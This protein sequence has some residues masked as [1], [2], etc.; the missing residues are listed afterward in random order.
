MQRSA[1]TY[2]LLAQTMRIF[3]GP[4]SLFFLTKYFS[5][6]ELGFYYSFFSIQASSQIIEAG[7]GF[8]LMQ[9]IARKMAGLKLHKGALIGSLEKKLII[10]KYF[11]FLILWQFLVSVIFIVAS[12]CI[13]LFIFKDYFGH[14]IWESPLLLLVFSGA[15]NL[16]ISCLGSMVEGLQ[17]PD[18][19]YRTSLV[20]SLGSTLSLL[21]FI[22]FDFGLYSAGLSQIIS[23]FIGAILHSITLRI[24]LKR[25][26]YYFTDRTVVSFQTFSSIFIEIRPY[27]SKI[28]A[29]WILG[30]FYWNA[31]NLI[32]FK[33]SGAEFAGKLG[34]TLALIKA[35]GSI[36]ESFVT[37]K[38]GMIAKLIG[39]GNQATALQ[40][41]KS[42]N[43][44]TA[45]AFGIGLTVVYL[46]AIYTP[47]FFS[48]KFLEL[49]QIILYGIGYFFIILITNMALY[50]R[51]HLVEPFVR[52]SVSQSII[53]PLGVYLLLSFIGPLSVSV[54]FFLL[55]MIYF[56][57]CLHIFRE[58]TNV[59][60]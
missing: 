25:A 56:F 53:F 8:V 50:I 40:V 34:F 13:G 20:A 52:F 10:Y 54:Y 39:E 41:F 43:A 12:Y 21:F 24:F 15:L 19:L 29:T 44:L 23:A 5:S 18:K 26:I 42:S 14:V 36:S 48:G 59:E 33:V 60:Q 1:I 57:W 46:I 38:R 17:R 30:F 2:F 27:F 51:C 7:I 37:T 31:L 35:V 11:F 4:L 22:Y 16:Y 32:S 55:H 9:T 6:E 45:A 49:N 28:S 3:S 58:F 47:V